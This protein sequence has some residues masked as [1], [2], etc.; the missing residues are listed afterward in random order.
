MYHQMSKFQYEIS[1]FDA[2]TANAVL[3]SV[4]SN[5]IPLPGQDTNAC[6]FTPCPVTSG[7]RQT[8]GFELPLGTHFPNVSNSIHSI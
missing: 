8:F 1:D 5:D 3:Y 7:T 4:T 6:N 2:T